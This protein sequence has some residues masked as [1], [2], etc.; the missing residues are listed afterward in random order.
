LDLRSRIRDGETYDLL[1]GALHID[2]LN[3]LTQDLRSKLFGGGQNMGSHLV[4]D[5]FVQDVHDAL[6]R[7]IGQSSMLGRAVVRDPDSLG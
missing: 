4:M 7:V 2:L 3:T 5:S 1:K 6:E